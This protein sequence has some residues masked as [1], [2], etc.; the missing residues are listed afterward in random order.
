M[1]SVH[2]DLIGSVVYVVYIL[3][4]YTTHIYIYI[5]IYVMAGVRGLDNRFSGLWYTQYILYISVFDRVEFTSSPPATFRSER[6]AG[7]A[8]R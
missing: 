3:Y 5:Y 7:L 1:W 4:I 2:R 8:R 6:V